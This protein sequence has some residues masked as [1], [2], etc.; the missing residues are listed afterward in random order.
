MDDFRRS[1]VPASGSWDCTD[2]LPFH[3]VLRIGEASRLASLQLLCRSRSL[4]RR[5][6]VRERRR[7]LP[8]QIPAPQRRPRLPHLR[9]HCPVR[10]PAWDCRRPISSSS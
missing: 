7:P 10:F 9:H 8:P 3:S 1:H 2:D 4:H 6:F 5:R